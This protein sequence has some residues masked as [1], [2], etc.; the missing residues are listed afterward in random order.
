MY[1]GDGWVDIVDADGKTIQKEKPTQGTE[2][3][4]QSMKIYRTKYH[5]P[6]HEGCDCTIL[7]RTG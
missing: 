1:A 3:N 4:V 2:D 7:P 6:I 5:A